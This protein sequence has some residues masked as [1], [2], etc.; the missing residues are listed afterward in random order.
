M[1]EKKQP[2]LRRSPPHEVCQAPPSDRRTVAPSG[3][4]EAIDRRSEI[5]RPCGLGKPRRVPYDDGDHVATFAATPR[6]RT[7]RWHSKTR[8]RRGA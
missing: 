1:R 5:D 2:E 4:R 6:H 3:D 8:D 7:T